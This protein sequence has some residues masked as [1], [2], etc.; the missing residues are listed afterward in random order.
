[1]CSACLNFLLGPAA[2]PLQCGLT[3][4]GG[5]GFRFLFNT[6]SLVFQKT[7]FSGGVSRSVMLAVS[8]T[9]AGPAVGRGTGWS[10]NASCGT[11]RGHALP[12]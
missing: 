6:L 11:C 2:R 7:D 4:F 1:M 9:F 12:R 8:A 10:R 5:V 3:V